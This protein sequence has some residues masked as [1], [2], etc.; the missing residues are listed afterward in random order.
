M[1]DFLLTHGLWTLGIMVFIDEI[2]LPFFPNG[3]ALFTLATLAPSV[4]EIHIWKYFLVAI[5]VAQTGQF[6]LF[7]GGQHGLRKWVKKHHTHLM[8]SEERLTKLKQFFAKK[9]GFLA[10]T[11]ISCITT[12]R[13]YFAL[14]AGSTEINP[15]KFFPFSFLGILLCTS[16]ITFSGYY[17]GESV[18]EIIKVNKTIVIIVITTLITLWYLKSRIP[19]RYFNKKKS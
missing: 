11:G 16:A 2:G 12:I 18:L 19:W 6:L 3:I 10:I 1:E 14:I 17:I 5:C 9:H 7:F 4:P 8:P 13:P 15:W